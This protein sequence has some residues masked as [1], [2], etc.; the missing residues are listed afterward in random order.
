MRTSLYFSLLLL[1]AACGGT[2]EE[3]AVDPPVRAIRADRVTI[4]DGTSVQTFNGVAEAAG[5]TPLSFRVAG[6]LRSLPVNLGQRVNRG[7]L[8]ATLDPADLQVQQSLAAAQRQASQA[9]VE[10]AETQLIAARAA[11][12]RTS[13]LYENNSVSLSQFEQV[14]SEFQSA[15]AQVEAARSQLE[16]SGAQARAAGNQV[17]YTRL[18]APFSGVI[19]EKHVEEN[20]YA[21]SGKAIVT[22]STEEN[23]EVEVNVPEDF[24]GRLS[25]GQR[26]EV[27]FSS[28]PGRTFPGTISEVAYAAAGSPSYPV[29]VSV[30]DQTEAIRP[31]MAATVRFHLGESTGPR[32]SLIVAPIASVSEG[33]DGRFVFRLEPGARDD[34]YVAR[35][36]PVDIG[37]YTTAGFVIR[38]G[39]RPGDLVATAGL[40]QLIDGMPVR[41]LTQ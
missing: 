13:R 25:S 31:G 16:A 34:Q 29:T 27:T 41:L 20:E 9:Q 38:E 4:S 39:L 30:S 22:L 40:N 32:D 14:R 5:R 23:P 1:L 7:Q 19:T 21:G 36:V 15:Q 3:V 17:A 28:I 8:I 2:T 35:R 37:D 11:Y 33:P 12:D 26:V 6:T 24:V 10:S 18:T